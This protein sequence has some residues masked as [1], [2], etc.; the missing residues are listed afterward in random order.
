MLDRRTGE[1][2]DLI[3]EMTH[4][5]F[6]RYDLHFNAD[7]IVFDWKEA[8]GKGFRI[9]EIDIDPV[10]GQRDERRHPGDLEG[11][12]LAGLVIVGERLLEVAEVGGAHS[13]THLRTLGDVGLEVRSRELNGG[14]PF[15]HVGRPMASQIGR[16]GM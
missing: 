6:G 5:I 14:R 13:A 11:E 8:E 15:T 9:Y 3:P 12:G 16:S 7:K 2:T 1:V 4:G 10:S